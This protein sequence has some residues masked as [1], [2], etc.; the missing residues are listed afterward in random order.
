MYNTISADRK[1]T[2]YLIGCISILL[3]LQAELEERLSTLSSY[4][5]RVRPPLPPLAA[6][7]VS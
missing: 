4:M 2:D 6:A 1:F 7:A 5:R 3:D